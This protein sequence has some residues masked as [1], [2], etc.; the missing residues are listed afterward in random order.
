MDKDSLDEKIIGYKLDS[1]KPDISLFPF[2]T[3]PNIVKV[4]E[5]GLIKYPKDNWKGLDKERILNALN[6]HLIA[7]DTEEIDRES[8]LP[9]IDHIACN[10]IML[11]YLNNQND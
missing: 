5:S 9:H 4:F 10:A 8:D 1:G 6:R 2:S 3:I 11:V 7:L